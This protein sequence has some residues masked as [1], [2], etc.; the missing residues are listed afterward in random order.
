VNARHTFVA[1]AAAC[2]AAALA[3][4]ARGQA[5]PPEGQA[6][7]PEGWLAV[8][9]A[10]PGR[11]AFVGEVVAFEVRVAVDAAWLAA[12]GVPLVRRELDQPFHVGVRAWTAA[13][14]SN[15]DVPPIVWREPATGEPTQRLAVG[16]RVVRAHVASRAGETP[17]V[18]VLQ[19]SW[20]APRA[21]EFV[22]PPVRV[23]AATATAFV[24]SLLGGRQP[25]E[26]VEHEVQ[27]EPMALTVQPLPPPPNG[28]S[29]HGAV[30]RFQ[31]ATE[32]VPADV[33]V[34]G[35]T[36][37][38]LHVR[39]EGNLEHLDPP[40]WPAV[41]GAH[42]QGMLEDRV[43]RPT[44]AART[45]VFDLL[46]VR[47]GH[48]TIP[49]LPFVFFDPD[50]ASYCTATAAPQ[51]LRVVPRPAGSPVD[52]RIAELIAAD[53]EALARA[54]ARPF[55]HWLVLAA[56]LVALA[57]VGLFGWSRRLRRR[58]ALLLVARVQQGGAPA[59]LFAAFEQALRVVTGAPDAATALDS[60]RRRDAPAAATLARVHEALGAARYGGPRPSVDD[61]V[62]ALR[63][64]L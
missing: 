13:G 28:A 64:F 34:G 49:A 14:S 55:W 23:R 5:S 29:F 44:T 33:V 60:L 12:H 46:A 37:L 59:E 39:G 62:A 22:L 11:A 57:A 56:V 16:D 10:G 52:A 36:E 58:A 61:A 40:P 51:A 3:V 53:R 43:E 48:L 35:T 20:M 2:F 50:T 63:R 15:D 24:D 42:V 41:P 25:V 6:S 45:F 1:A 54:G 38:R 32:V 17:T 26:V 21:G 4:P 31:V 9:V 8:E 18:L 30:G 47:E 19:A 7:P 27:S